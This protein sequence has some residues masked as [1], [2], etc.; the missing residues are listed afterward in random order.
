MAL[1]D[2]QRSL[3]LIRLHAKDWKVDPHKIGVLGFS[4][5]GNLAIAL[6]THFEKRLYPGGDEADKLSCRPDFALAIYPAYLQPDDAKGL[7]LDSN[8]PV[9]KETPSTFIVHA[10]DDKVIDS[11]NSLAYYTAL[12]KCGVPVEMHLYAE[13]GH[14][15][16]MRKSKLPITNWPQLAESWLHTIGII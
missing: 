15:F 10:Q 9:S 4:A 5:G 2:A 1:E 3:G 12:K 8:I 13:G 16:G 14:G 11:Q 7:E 6:S